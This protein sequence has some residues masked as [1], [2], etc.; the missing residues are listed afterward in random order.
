[1]HLHFLNAKATEEIKE[2]KIEISMHKQKL[3]EYTKN[4]KLKTENMFITNIREILIYK[5]EL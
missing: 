4:E 3:T 2:I 1:M 5:E